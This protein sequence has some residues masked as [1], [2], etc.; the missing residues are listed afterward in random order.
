MCLYLD[1]S[2]KTANISKKEL[3]PSIAKKDITVYKL[4]S[5]SGKFSKNRSIF[6]EFLYTK[7]KEHYR[8]GPKK[9]GI[10]VKKDCRSW[11]RRKGKF[12][13]YIEDGLH[14]YS[15]KEVAIKACFNNEKVVKM[16]IPK[17]AEYYRGN[18]GKHIVTDRLIWY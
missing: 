7:G 4:L 3:K 17:G 8:Y 2:F 15:S 5:K 13:V 1:K 6:H 12:V 16:I 10:V 11:S 9:F 18:Q 14:V